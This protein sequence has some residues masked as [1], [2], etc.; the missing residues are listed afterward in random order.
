MNK[1]IYNAVYIDCEEVEST[2]AKVFDSFE[3][4]MEYAKKMHGEHKPQ[5]F[6]FR[7]EYENSY[8]TV[9]KKGKKSTEYDTTVFYQICKIV[10]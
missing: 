10:V 3:E 5:Y 7:E 1:W 9:R 4:A 2:G 8:E 6:S